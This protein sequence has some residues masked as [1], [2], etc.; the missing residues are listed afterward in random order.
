MTKRTSLFTGFLVAM[1]LGLPLAAQAQERR[2]PLEDAPAVR[3]RVELRDKRFEIGVGGGTSVGADFYHAVT[4]NGRL[5]FHFTDWLAISAWGAFNVVPDLKT[6]FHEKLVDALK[7]PPPN[8]DR[9]PT[10]QEA[11]DGMNRIG[12]AFAAQLELIP[13]TGKFGLFSKLFMNYDFYLFGGVGAI[14]FKADGAC[15]ARSCPVTGFKIG[16]NFGLGMHLF[17]NDFFALNFELRD[18]LVQNNAAG[19]DA[20]GDMVVNDRDMSWNSNYLFSLNLMFFLP[21]RATISP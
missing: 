14:D 5:A 11:T 4:V 17:A 20:N 2:S 1:A 9:T 15:G 12:E 19:R 13:F 8:P 10:V 18:I 7:V 6:S 3:R 21:G 16:G